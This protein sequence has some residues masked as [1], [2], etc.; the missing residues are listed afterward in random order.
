[1]MRIVQPFTEQ[2]MM[3]PHQTLFGMMGSCTTHKAMPSTEEEVSVV[4]QQMRE[5]V[6]H[7]AIDG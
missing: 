7:K 6:K 2:N 1:M 4:I 3:T 5:S